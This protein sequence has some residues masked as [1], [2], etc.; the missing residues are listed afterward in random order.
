MCEEVCVCVVGGRGEVLAAACSRCWRAGG[1]GVRGVW[2]QGIWCWC[3]EKRWWVA[4]DCKGMTASVQHAQGRG[5]PAMLGESVMLLS[6]SLL[7]YPP[8][9]KVTP[10]PRRPLLLFV[11]QPPT[12]TQ[13]VW[14]TPLA[15]SPISP[16]PP[17]PSALTPWLLFLLLA[18][19]VCA[20]HSQPQPAVGSAVRPLRSPLAPLP[21]SS[22]RA[23]RT[24]SLCFP[25]VIHNPCCPLTPPPRGPPHSP[26]PLPAGL[27]P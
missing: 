25:P 2:G 1:G 3:G 19:A 12:G 16:S 14:P 5:M 7:L 27:A 22:S 6:L 23:S 9:P 20:P 10:P 17:N 8:P 26:P 21:S 24:A 18:A 13:W 15:P 4:I 11:C